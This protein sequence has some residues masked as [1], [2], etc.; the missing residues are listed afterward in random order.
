MADRR[1]TPPVFQPTSAIW[2][3]SW[4]GLAGLWQHPLTEMES[5]HPRSEQQDMEVTTDFMSPHDVILREKFNLRL[6]YGAT[7]RKSEVATKQLTLQHT[8]IWALGVHELVPLYRLV[9]VL[10]GHPAVQHAKNSK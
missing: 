1:L 8:K 2:L 10:P 4:Q 6:G 5:V 3:A 7:R 9:D